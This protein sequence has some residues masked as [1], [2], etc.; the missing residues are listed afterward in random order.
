MITS[1]SNL[2]CELPYKRGRI[3]LVLMCRS[4]VGEG[5]GGGQSGRYMYLVD[6]VVVGASTLNPHFRNFIIWII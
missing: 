4:K 3:M 2:V 6:K 1:S 5:P